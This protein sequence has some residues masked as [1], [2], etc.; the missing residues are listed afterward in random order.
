MNMDTTQLECFIDLAET[1]NFSI[2]AQ[3]MYLTQPT[4]SNKIK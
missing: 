4:I 3:R 1:L 2:T